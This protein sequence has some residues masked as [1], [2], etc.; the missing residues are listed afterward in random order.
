MTY[1]NIYHS[2]A[3]GDMLSKL[4][5]D[6]LDF[7]RRH[8][9][10]FEDSDFFPRLPAYQAVW[11]DWENVRDR[12][13]SSN[14][15][16]LPI[17]PADSMPVAKGKSSY[18]IVHQLDP[19]TCLT[20][21][22]LAYRVGPA[23]EAARVPANQHVAFSNR[24][25]PLDGAFFSSGTGYDEYKEKSRQL[26]NNH[27]FAATADISDFF[28]QIYSHRVR[29]SIEA[30]DCRLDEV[31]QDFESVIHSINAGASKG[32][33]VGP[34]A[35]NLISE[36]VLIDVDQLLIRNGFKH[37]RYVDDI[38]IFD[39]D[40]YALQYA[41]ELLSMYLYENHRLNLNGRKTNIYSREEFSEKVLQDHM[42]T[43]TKAAMQRMSALDPYGEYADVE[44]GPALNAEILD[45]IGL[46][47]RTKFAADGYVDLN[48]IKAYI[49][50]ARASN[51]TQFIN[52]ASA[53]LD[54]FLPVFHELAKALDGVIQ[55]GGHEI[56]LPLIRQIAVSG[57]YRRQAVRRWWDWIC[58]GSANLLQIRPIQTA[59][60]SGEI[61]SQARAAVSLRDLAWVRSHRSSFMQF[62]PMDRA[63]VV[64]AMEILGRDERRAILNQIDDTQAS[65]ID[66]A[67]KRFVLR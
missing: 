42:D 47:I 40:R 44:V 38:R 33:P 17:V 2:V 35:S 26:A 64:G 49:R 31:A 58:A 19:L 66:L 24:F 16:K 61:R 10:R 21:T 67:M 37:V 57:Y 20:Y 51:S 8:L 48:L 63:A 22:A 4:T 36:A 43:E 59:V 45:E 50:R 65:P 29:G 27:E 39:N 6:S 53:S 41:I 28:N 46:T 7:A 11:A 3:W 30:A 13:M 1:A 12:L 34:N 62:A 14:I 23:I 18:R 9:E 55:S 56:A 60:F 32:I 25:S 15:K 5:E 54:A 52:V